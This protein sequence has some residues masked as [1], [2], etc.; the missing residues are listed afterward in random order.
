MGE[1]HQEKKIQKACLFFQTKKGCQYKDLC[2]YLHD[3]SLK[4]S[5]P[6][7]CKWFN[8]AGGCYKGE[9]CFFSHVSL[10][11]ENTKVCGYGN[12]CVFYRIGKCKWKHED[13][14]SENPVVTREAKTGRRKKNVKTGCNCSHAVRTPKSKVDEVLLEV[15]KGTKILKRKLA[16]KVWPGLINL[17]LSAIASD[18]SISLSE[19]TWASAISIQVNLSDVNSDDSGFFGWKG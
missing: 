13:S 14:K 19:G 11:S 8:S 15:E 9:N 17:I 16:V 7:P 2:P 10:Y 3:S 5:S 6:I 1:V 4:P 18:S 12:S